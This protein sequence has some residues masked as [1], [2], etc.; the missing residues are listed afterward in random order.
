MFDRCPAFA[1]K[2]KGFCVTSPQRCTAFR[3][4]AEYV[5]DA[6]IVW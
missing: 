5:S 1:G 3:I 4:L 6:H 2:T